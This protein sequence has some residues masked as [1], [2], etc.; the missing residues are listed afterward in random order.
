MSIVIL[1]GNECMKCEYQKLCK[2]YKCRAKIYNKMT[3]SFKNRIGSPDLLIFFTNT[4]SHKMLRSAMSE[5]KGSSTI[6]ERSHSSSKEA[7]KNI[8]SKYYAKEQVS[9]PNFTL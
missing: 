5:T 3:G 1:G 4:M 2:E 6:I 8:L 9:W 7:L